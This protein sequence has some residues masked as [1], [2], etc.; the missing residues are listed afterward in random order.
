MKNRSH[1][2]DHQNQGMPLDEVQGLLPP[3]TRSG[4]LLEMILKQDIIHVPRFDGV[5]KHSEKNE[6]YVDSKFSN[7]GPLNVTI[8]QVSGGNGSG[9]GNEYLGAE[10]TLELKPTPSPLSET[11][12]TLASDNNDTFTGNNYWAEFGAQN[13]M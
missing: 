13:K 3:S 4:L 6:K 7:R 1:H 2:H 11:S 5:L 8:V 10:P 9:G 12:A